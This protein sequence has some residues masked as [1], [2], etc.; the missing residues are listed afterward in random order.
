M[1]IVAFGHRKRVGKDKAA[2]FL[3]SHLRIKHRGLS[4]IRAGFA[5]KVKAVCYDLYKHRGLQS[6]DFYE[7]PQNEHLR[8]VILPSLNLTPRQVWINLANSI[9]ASVSEATWFEY[10]LENTKADVLVVKDMRFPIEADGILA[11]G[12]KIYRIDRSEGSIDVDGADEALDDYD[13]WTG[14]ITNDGTLHE[15]H[16]KI[17]QIAEGLNV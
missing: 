9:R 3:I 10:L 11:K 7:E 4:I 5:D 17:V 13:R 16:N 2:Q 1:L 15:F 14:T 12:G 8:E 6:A